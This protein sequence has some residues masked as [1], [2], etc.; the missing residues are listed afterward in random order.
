[1]TVKADW[2][3]Q[4]HAYLAFS[5]PMEGTTS[6]LDIQGTHFQP[7]LL[8]GLNQ[9]RPTL[10]LVALPGGWLVQVT[11]EVSSLRICTM[12]I[13]RLLSLHCCMPQGKSSCTRHAS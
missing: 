2:Q 6:V 10:L 9:N 11:D 12:G 1:M 13:M 5:F 7:T 8:P 4:H 3:Q